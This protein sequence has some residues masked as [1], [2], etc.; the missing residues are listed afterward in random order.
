MTG[1][2]LWGVEFFISGDEVYFSELSPRPHD[3]GMV[4]LSGTQIF[5][6]FEL[7]C[8]AIL[9]LP[10][11]AITLQRSGVSAVILHMNDEQ[12][13]PTFIGIDKALEI[14]NSDIRIFGKPITRKY[15]RMGIAL[16]WDVKDAD[17]K[18]LRAK[19]KEIADCIT[20]HPQH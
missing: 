5:T 8:R 10:I 14:E 11:P 12:F 13:I 9:G 7:H 19:A 4:T 15:R 16:T 2:G 20:I 6:E 1:A 17:I 3:T 18:A